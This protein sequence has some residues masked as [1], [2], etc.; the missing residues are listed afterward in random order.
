MSYLLLELQVSRA[1]GWRILLGVGAL[2][3]LVVLKQAF[4]AKESTE[5]NPAGKAELNHP[6]VDL[7][8]ALARDDLLRRKFIGAALG[9]FLFDITFYGNVIFTPIILADT[10]GFDQNHLTSVT[11]CALLV[12]AIGLP[13]YY[14]TIAFVG[15]MSFRTIQILG[16]SMMAVLF[17]VLGVF[18]TQLLPYRALLLTLYALTFFFSNFGPNVSTFSLPAEIFPSDVRVKLNGIAAACG[19]LGATV[20]AAAFGLIEDEWG[21]SHVLIISALVSALGVIVTHR[22]IPQRQ[23]H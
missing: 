21:V 17:L 11:L 3:G 9:W 10:Y 22:Y 6:A 12:A 19:K 14:V 2:P 4:N 13:G 5:H 15:R 20:G 8:S 16:F 1:I 23:L 7:W 18:Y